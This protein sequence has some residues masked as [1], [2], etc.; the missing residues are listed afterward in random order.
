MN[1]SLLKRL[2]KMSSNELLGEA[3]GFKVMNVVYSDK[4]FR[5]NYE[6]ILFELK[7][8]KLKND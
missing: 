7:E 2:K 8:R 5:R 1:K 3:K 6:T 4:R